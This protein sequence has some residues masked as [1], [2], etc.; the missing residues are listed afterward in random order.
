[1]NPHNTEAF[2]FCTRNET[3]ISNNGSKIQYSEKEINCVEFQK[4]INKLYDDA[5]K[6]NDG[7]LFSETT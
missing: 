1:M 4:R 2:A 3:H 7:S 5:I 6:N